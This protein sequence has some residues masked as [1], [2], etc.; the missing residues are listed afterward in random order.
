MPIPVEAQTAMALSL[1]DRSRKTAF[2]L[3]KCFVK[4]SDGATTAILVLPLCTEQEYWIRRITVLVGDTSIL[5]L[6]THKSWRG[7]NGNDESTYRR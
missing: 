1:S 5:T 4:A 7:T 3:E 2:S 6:Q